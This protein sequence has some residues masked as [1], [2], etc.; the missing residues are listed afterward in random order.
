[1]KMRTDRCQCGEVCYKSLGKSVALYICHCREC[2]KQS[3]SA[4]GITLDIRRQGFQI[5]Q[6]TPK[7]WRR[8]TDSGGKLKCAS[9]Q[10]AAHVCGMNLILILK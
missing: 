5:T 3:A 1:M 4:F 8:T 2:Q 9:V 6:G 7:Y 10:L